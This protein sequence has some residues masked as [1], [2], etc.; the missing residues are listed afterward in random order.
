MLEIDKYIEQIY[1]TNEVYIVYL[2]TLMIF[3]V[4]SM[5]S[6]FVARYFLRIREVK[7]RA[8]NPSVA[9]RIAAGFD[10]QLPGDTAS[11]SVSATFSK[12]ASRFVPGV[13]TKSSSTI[14]DDLIEAGFHDPSVL[15]WYYVSRIIFSVS[16]PAIGFPIVITSGYAQTTFMTTVF[17]ILLALI[18]MIIPSL[19]IMRRKRQLEAEYRDGFPELMD[20]LVVCTEAGIGLAAAINRVTNE[21]A[22]T[23]KNLGVNMHI[24]TL[25]LRAGKSLMEAFDSF[26]RRV[27]IDEVRSLGSLLQQSEELGTSLTEAL[28]VYSR[29][30]REK[31][32]FRAEEKAYALPAKM[33]LPLGLFVF[34][35]LLIVIMLPLIIRIN[36]AFFS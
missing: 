16:L 7:T 4:V 25:E 18:G 23:H 12:V 28:R 14:R 34:P 6:Y 26:G 10:I 11:A 32:F 13:E 29:E 24:M 9:G 20:L 31:R 15:A 17:L 3:L 36:T 22:K 33:V 1:D 27:T 8:Y 35:V 2:F 30:M 21:I 19:Y 5:I